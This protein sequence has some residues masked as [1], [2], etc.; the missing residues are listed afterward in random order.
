MSFSL[1]VVLSVSQETKVKNVIIIKINSFFI[2][3]I[4]PHYVLL[5]NIFMLLYGGKH[6][7]VKGTK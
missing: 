3:D 2:N 1:S 6:K 5:S 7:F 4:V